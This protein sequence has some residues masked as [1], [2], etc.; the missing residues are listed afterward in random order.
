MGTQ[1]SGLRE[2]NDKI[3]SLFNYL[4]SHAP[5]A[6]RPIVRYTVWGG[7]RVSAASNNRARLIRYNV[8]AKSR[9]HESVVGARQ[10]GDFRWLKRRRWLKFYC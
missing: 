4:L 2:D 7:S 3:I 8:A 5:T 10:E 6:G 1:Y 9:Q